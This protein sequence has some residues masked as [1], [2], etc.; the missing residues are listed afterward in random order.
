MRDMPPKPQ[1]YDFLVPYIGPDLLRLRR[2]RG[3]TQ[4]KLAKAAGMSDGTLG[5]IEAG[6]G[7]LSE[8]RLVALCAVLGEDVDQVVAR[9]TE[10]LAKDSKRRPSGKGTG[11]PA[12]EALR[13]LEDE[14]RE[15]YDERLR[16][17]RELLEVFIKWGRQLVEG[18]KTKE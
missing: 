16:L 4:V 5:K 18:G 10:R 15:R 8:E 13:G 6:T 12:E 17:D 1:K 9:A 11:T 2:K 3:L 7:K 14:L